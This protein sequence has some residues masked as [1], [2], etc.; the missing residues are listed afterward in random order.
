MCTK[1]LLKKETLEEIE[2]YKNLQIGQE[3]NI[4]MNHIKFIEEYH[5]K[6]L[7]NFNKFEFNGNKIVE[8]YNYNEF[9]DIIYYNGQYSYLKPIL[10]DIYNFNPNNE[11]IK[12]IFIRYKEIYNNKKPNITDMFDNFAIG[13]Y[14]FD[15]INNKKYPELYNFLNNLYY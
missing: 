1:I 4:I 8:T 2:K 5:R 13:Q 10:E 6:P 11:Q 14:Y 9:H 3:Y 7:S 15:C 12:N